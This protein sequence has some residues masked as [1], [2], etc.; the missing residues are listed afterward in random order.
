[1]EPVLMAPLR[2]KW[3]AV[4]EQARDL[5]RRR[6]ETE[7]RRARDN[8]QKELTS[9]LTGFAYELS[10]VQVLDPA[11]GSGNFLYVALRQLLDLE[12]EVITFA[13]DIGV[14]SFFP[15]VSPDQLHGIEINEYA[16]ELAQTT[17]WI[18]YIQWLHDNGFGVPGEPILKPL[19]NIRL[20][21]AILAYDEAGN[22]VEPDWPEADVVIGNPP[23]L[24]GKKMR[25]ELGD[26]YV[27]DLFRLYA[28]RVPHEADLVTYW[29]ERSR[30]MIAR[31]RLKRAGLLATQG[32]RGGANRKIL[33]RIKETGDIFWAESDRDWLLDGAIVHVSMIGFDDGTEQ[34]RTLDGKTVKIINADLTSSI[35]L[36]MAKP[37]PENAELSFMGV[38][39]AGPFYV[40][41]ETAKR[42]MAAPNPHGRPNSDV[43]KS[44]FNGT[45][46]N[47]RPRDVWII[48]FG[49]S[50]TLEEAAQYELPFEY[51]REH[52]YP[53]RKNNKR[54]I[55]REKWWL[56]A[57]TR[58]AMREALQPLSRYIG[59]SL[60]S[61]HRFFRWIASEVIPAN[62]IIVIARDDDYFFGV[63]HGKPHLLWAKSM[64]TQLED[65]PRYTPTTCFETYPFPWPPG[66]EDPED[67]RVQAIAEA[68]RELDEKRNAWLNPPGLSEKE[69]K[70]RTLTNLYNQRPTWLDL[71]H[72]KLDEAVFAAY[73]WPADLSD[74]EILERL[75][76][77]NLA[78]AGV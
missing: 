25:T 6:D 48:D 63:L 67:P 49:V 10:Q 15:S 37:L 34:A 70:K 54:R 18:G 11:C 60:V 38:T 32:I 4:Q 43:V 9:L 59:T 14:G 73:G 31:G 1:V 2:R 65:R 58:P 66:E 55:Y 21:D 50:R 44:Y 78:R 40:D 52:V 27:D 24:G 74:E 64:G 22:P 51:V 5:A 76:A 12:K 17:I 41:G 26:A 7:S 57:E 42:W 46:L 23:F 45:D 71:A 8:R 30:E 19:H 39:P 75:L 3:E 33:E 72:R 47:K 62:L 35:D 29:F 61:K 28:G 20:M 13:R 16:H 77:L 69:L 56:L 68:A 36:T 53:V